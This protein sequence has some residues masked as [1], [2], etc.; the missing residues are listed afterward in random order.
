[1]IEGSF[2]GVKLVKIFTRE[3]QPNAAAASSDRNP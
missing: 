3:W 2:E 1:M